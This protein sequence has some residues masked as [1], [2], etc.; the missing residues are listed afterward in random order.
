MRV[1]GREL[2]LE[3]RVEGTWL[4]LELRVEGRE[5]RLG[6][7]VEGTWLRLELR[8]EGTWL[9]LG[10]RVEGRELRLN[11]ITHHPGSNRTSLPRITYALVRRLTCLAS[12]IVKYHTYEIKECV[13]E[14]RKAFCF[15]SDNGTN[16]NTPSGVNTGLWS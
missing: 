7:R 2:R 12:E 8:V 16:D 10:L 15:S 13:Y 9:R 6:L 4:R 1:E 3:L 5:L 11:G 14:S